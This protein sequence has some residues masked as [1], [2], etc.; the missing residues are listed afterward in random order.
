MI[1]YVI[2]S[3]GEGNTAVGLLRLGPNREEVWTR[4][5]GGSNGIAG[6][7]FQRISDDEYIMSCSLFDNGD[8]TYNAYLIKINDS[9]DIMWDASFG[10]IENDKA[11][12]VIQ[13][14]DGG[15]AVVGSTNNFGNGDKF[16]SDLWLIKTDSKGYSTNWDH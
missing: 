2:E 11:R 8:N 16:T 10:D 12:S 13:T 5:I 4:T 3:Y 1:R 15:Y 7:S 14:L 9:G 6:T